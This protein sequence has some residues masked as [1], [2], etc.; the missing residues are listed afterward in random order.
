M[1]VAIIG[2]SPFEGIAGAAGFVLPRIELQAVDEDGRR[3]PPGT[4]GS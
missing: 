4:G 3:L 1:V 2:G